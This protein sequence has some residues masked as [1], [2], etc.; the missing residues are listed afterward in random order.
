M[1]TP[2]ADALCSAQVARLVLSA[3]AASGTDPGQ[4]SRDARLPGWA[5]TDGG[6]RRLRNGLLG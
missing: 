5:L 6:A 4:L 3:A 2:P 1:T